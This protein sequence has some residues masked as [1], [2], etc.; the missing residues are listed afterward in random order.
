MQVIVLAPDTALL[1]QLHTDINALLFALGYKPAMLLTRA[2]KLSGASSNEKH[3]SDVW[4]HRPNVVMGSPERVLNF[5]RYPPFWELVVANLRLCVVDEASVLGSDRH[6]PEFLLAELVA[7]AQMRF[8]FSSG[9]FSNMRTL[10]GGWLQENSPSR[11]W[12]H[13]PNLVTLEERLADDADGAVRYVLRGP[14]RPVPLYLTLSPT[15]P[16]EARRQQGS[17]NS[18]IAAALAKLK[19]ETGNGWGTGCGMAVV[20]TFSRHDAESCAQYLQDSQLCMAAPPSCQPLHNA[21]ANLCGPIAKVDANALHLADCLAKSVAFHHAGLS[22]DARQ[23]VDELVR[24]QL[25]RILVCT[26]TLA[27]GI[28][29]PISCGVAAD[30]SISIGETRQPWDTVVLRQLIARCG[31]MGQVTTQ[32]THAHFIALIRPSLMAQQ[33]LWLSKPSIVQSRLAPA[34][35]AEPPLA[36]REALALMLL[37]R[38]VSRPDA[39]C[40]YAELT[41]LI[42]RSL[43]VHDADCLLP[44]WFLDTLKATTELLTECSLSLVTAEQDGYQATEH[45]RLVAQYGLDFYAVQV[46]CPQVATPAVRSQ[47]EAMSAI[48][49]VLCHALGGAP[50]LKH[51]CRVAE[52]RGVEALAA[53]DGGL[54][55]V[56]VLG[57]DE[58]A[59]LSSGQMRSI[60]RASALLQ[61]LALYGKVPGFETAAVVLLADTLRLL[62]ALERWFLASGATR[63]AG[64][65]VSWQHCLRDDGAGRLAGLMASPDW[66]AIPDREISRNVRI[67]TYAAPCMQAVTPGYKQRMTTSVHSEGRI[68]GL[69]EA[70]HRRIWTEAGKDAAYQ[71]SAWAA[72]QSAKMGGLILE[73]NTS[74]T[75]LTEPTYPPYQYVAEVGGKWYVAMSHQGYLKCILSWTVA[76]NS[77]TNH[78][79][80]KGKGSG[81]D[82][83][84]HFC[85]CEPFC[86][87]E[88]AAVAW[89]SA[90]EQAGATGTTSVHEFPTHMGGYGGNPCSCIDCVATKKCE[91]LVQRFIAL[92]HPHIFSQRVVGSSRPQTLVC[93]ANIDN[94]TMR[95][96][97]WDREMPRKGSPSLSLKALFAD[98]ADARREARC[99]LQAHAL[100]WQMHL[101]LIPSTIVCHGAGPSSKCKNEQCFRTLGVWGHTLQAAHDKVIC[102][103]HARID[104]NTVWLQRAHSPLPFATILVALS[105]W[106]AAFRL[107]CEASGKQLYKELKHAMPF[108][109]FIHW[110]A[111]ASDMIAM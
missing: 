49:A 28:N 76:C 40:G 94:T 24:K 92:A 70:D 9:T 8:I 62:Q 61:H 43:F 53:A 34:V 86:T 14:H 82:A 81:R 38:I 85:F 66:H 23:L 58:C 79:R 57:A 93:G 12:Q 102:G 54:P 42:H 88:E 60:E 50:S 18:A 41:A 51:Y 17:L 104:G 30:P 22:L 96:V 67:T 36:A 69:T 13:V 44:Q 37:G 108:H 19:A 52:A 78:I 106:L 77:F 15:A 32:I 75:D 74:Q 7:I 89:A 48:L 73:P 98:D 1:V 5:V 35:Q 2:E 105:T 26:T 100:D 109:L 84:H 91:K 95:R 110:L 99:V 107:H 101:G 71:T 87:A 11:G 31:R 21:I 25:I 6:A 16:D 39:Y 46:F 10:L 27:F 4:Q 20:F 68:F 65:V 47:R 80:H 56:S 111:G 83:F 55:F 63:L 103:S 97:I 59:C 45:G 3:I 33:V 90:L 72:L 29:Y 64:A